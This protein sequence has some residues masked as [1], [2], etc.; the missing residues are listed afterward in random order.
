MAIDDKESLIEH[1]AIDPFPDAEW[2]LSTG[3]DVLTDD[4]VMAVLMIQVGMAINAMNAQLNAGYDAVNRDP[5]RSAGVRN[6]DLTASFMNVCALMH[7]SIKLAKEYHA[8]L[9]SFALLNGADEELL[10]E[11]QSLI[12]GQH[13]ASPLLKKSR[14]KLTFHWDPKVIGKSLREYEK[15]A[16]LTWVESASAEVLYRL[17]YEVLNHAMFPEA[18]TPDREKAT[19]VIAEAMDR[20]QAAAGTLSS[21]FQHSIAAYLRAAG[22]DLKKRTPATVQE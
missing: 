19:A 18:D 10:N 6:R 1:P 8:D 16:A 12:D 7:E 9:K 13:L 14:N 15:N 11:V 3:P 4:R 21:F 2:W 22:G 5:K 17:A 20:M